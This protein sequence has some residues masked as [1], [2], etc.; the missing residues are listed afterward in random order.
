MFLGG[1]CWQ[2]CKL[3]EEK[4]KMKNQ[5]NWRSLHSLAK[6]NK[7]MQGDQDCQIYLS[8]ST[9]LASHDYEKSMKEAH[10]QK[11]HWTNGTKITQHIKSGVYDINTCLFPFRLLLKMLEV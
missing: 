11:I 5:S 1:K 9:G 2:D 8:D 4:E 6:W 10:V 7:K 3:T